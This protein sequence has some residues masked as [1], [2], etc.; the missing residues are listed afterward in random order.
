MLI[1]EVEQ[2]LS[3]RSAVE[4]CDWKRSM[5]SAGVL[6]VWEAIGNKRDLDEDQKQKQQ[7]AVSIEMSQIESVSG[8][9]RVGRRR[10]DQG[11]TA[12]AASCSMQHAAAGLFSGN[13]A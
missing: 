13:G 9:W 3:N 7:V 12:S 10:G 2:N 5:E 8:S 6:Y 11:N 1:E 4:S